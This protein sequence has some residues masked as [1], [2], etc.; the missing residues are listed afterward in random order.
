MEILKNPH[1]PEKNVKTA[2]CGNHA[3]LRKILRSRGVETIA[4]SDDIRLPAYIRN[5][6]D[7]QC[8]HIGNGVILTS[9]QDLEIDGYS[10]ELIPEMPSDSYPNDCFLNCFTINNILI[11]G[12]KCSRKIIEYAER[13]S[14]EIRFVNQGYAKCSAAIINSNAVITADKTISQ[15]L[16]N[17]CDVLMTDCGHI[18][19]EGYNYGFIGGA[20]GKLSADSI[21][22]YGNPFRHPDGKRII[23]FAE[24]HNC[25]VESLCNGELIDFGGF[26]PLS[27]A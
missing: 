12:K 15:A 20:C 17:D 11:A 1:L 5:H 13:N 3:E 18:F 10:V 19:L 4:V 24:E 2:I 16:E 9:N 25:G 26:I 7:I 6:A 27:E 8:C 23:S 14:L 21:A 22:F